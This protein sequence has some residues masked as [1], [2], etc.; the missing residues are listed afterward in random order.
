M[1]FSIKSD[2]LGLYDE[3]LSLFMSLMIFFWSKIYFF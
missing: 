2:F 3:D 1:S